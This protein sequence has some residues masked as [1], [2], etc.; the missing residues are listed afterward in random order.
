LDKSFR[1]GVSYFEIENGIL[2]YRTQDFEAKTNK[3]VREDKKCYGIN[4]LSYFWWSMIG[5][6]LG[7]IDCD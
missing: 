1:K 4:N 3:V 2:I 7:K 6:K 5:H